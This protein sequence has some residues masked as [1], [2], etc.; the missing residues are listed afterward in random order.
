MS[1]QMDTNFRGQFDCKRPSYTG[2]TYSITKLQALLCHMTYHTSTVFLLS[3]RVTFYH[4]QSFEPKKAT[5][6]QN[7][8]D[9]F[10]RYG[11]NDKNKISKLPK[12]NHMRE[13]IMHI[14]KTVMQY[15]CRVVNIF[16]IDDTSSG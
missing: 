9:S 4:Y 13:K 16:R 2:F 10:P 11:I 14:S 7:Y 15:I 6:N 8:Q 3:R 5:T 12:S 1:Q